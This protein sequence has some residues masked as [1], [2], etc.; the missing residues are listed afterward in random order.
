MEATF[1]KTALY[2]SNLSIQTLGPFHLIWPKIPLWI[3]EHNFP[4][5][6]GTIF[7]RI[8]VKEGKLASGIPKL[9]FDNFLPIFPSEFGWMVQISEIHQFSH[10]PGLFPVNFCTNSLPFKEFH[11]FWLDAKLAC[12]ASVSAQFGSTVLFLAL[13]P[14]SG[15]AKYRKPRSSVFLCSQT[16]RKR[17]LRRLMGSF[18][19]SFV[20]TV[21]FFFSLAAKAGSALGSSPSSTEWISLSFAISWFQWALNYS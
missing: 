5:G 2:L 18:H 21:L 14:F 8:T 19:E 17:L 7:S 6:N 1:R 4:L 16:L 20:K 3:S 15:Q 9:I 10:F 11:S 13:A 12:V